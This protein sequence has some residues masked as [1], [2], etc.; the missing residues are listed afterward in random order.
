[1]D[2]AT[3]R[4]GDLV[5]QAR[6]RFRVLA[7]ASGLQAVGYVTI[8]AK[9]LLGGSWGI[10]AAVG[11]VIGVMLFLLVQDWGNKIDQRPQGLNLVKARTGAGILLGMVPLGPVLCPPLLRLLRQPVLVH[12]SVANHPESGQSPDEDLLDTIR[13]RSAYVLL[14]AWALAFVGVGALLLLASPSGNWT[15]Q[16]L[17]GL[18][19][20]GGGA[21]QALCGI[22]GVV[23]LADLNPIRV[24]WVT[25]LSYLLWPFL[26][27]GTYA[28]WATRRAF[29]GAA[30]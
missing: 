4:V 17:V 25:R 13:V 1:M 21:L 26:P 2:S 9:Y 8:V 6:R 29:G 10:G 5:A 30:F 12:Y 7:V 19:V 11:T 23:L 3:L 16:D 20:L 14:R 28:A 24:V 27:F 15:A 22:A 18:V